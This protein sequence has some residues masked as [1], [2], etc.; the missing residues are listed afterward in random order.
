MDILDQIARVKR[1]EVIRRRAS[2]PAGK[3][4]KSHAF[5]QPVPS[6]YDALA[7]PGPSVIAEFKRRSPSKGEIS[8]SADVA[9]VASDY[10]NAG[11]AAMSVLTD[12]EF[13]G[14]NNYDLEKARCVTSFPILRKDFVIDEYQI[15]E[16]R[17]IGASAI[18]LIGAILTKIEIARFASLAKELALDILFEIHD[19]TD[20]EKISADIN[21]IGVNNRNLRTFGVNIANSTELL[22]HLPLNC[23]K[24]AESGISSPKEAIS[25]YTSGFDAFLIGE[26]FMKHNDPGAAAASFI[27]E[28]SRAAR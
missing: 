11:A 25:L 2:D 17:S 18:L 20:L 16:A 4:E 15:I 7:K 14:G 8:V 27:N 12:T 26:G 21:I 22:K 24:V 28:L 10:E 9:L 19:T 13:F 3:L 6:L 5:S 23:L 1:E